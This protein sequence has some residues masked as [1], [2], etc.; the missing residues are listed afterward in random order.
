MK[1]LLSII[2]IICVILF[3][4]NL[5]NRVY[6]IEPISNKEIEEGSEAYIK[7][8]N[9]EIPEFRG[10]S[11]PAKKKNGKY[12]KEFKECYEYVINNP[13]DD[14]F[15]KEKNENNESSSN[16]IIIALDNIEK[17]DVNCEISEDAC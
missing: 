10:K 5:N 8:E 7:C 6:F 3:F 12:R 14:V 2:T 1:F 17:T 16:S 11:Y 15:K 13:V 9:G 4:I